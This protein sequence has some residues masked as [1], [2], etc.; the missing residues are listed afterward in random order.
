LQY[1][2]IELVKNLTDIIYKELPPTVNGSKRL[3]IAQR[4]ALELA[5]KI[6]KESADLTKRPNLLE[7]SLWLEYDIL[8]SNESRRRLFSLVKANS[9]H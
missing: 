9:I 6:C 8:I 3:A 5:N 1:E 2:L 7:Y 4:V